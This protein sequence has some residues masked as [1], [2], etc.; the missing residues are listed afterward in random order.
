MESIYKDM[1]AFVGARRAIPSKL[2][3]FSSNFG[4]DRLSYHIDEDHIRNFA[5]IVTSELKTNE[6]YSPIVIYRWR[7]VNTLLVQRWIVGGSLGPHIDCENG[8]ALS[9]LVAFPLLE[10]IAQKWTNAWDDSGKAIVEIPAEAGLLAKN[11]KPKCIKLGARVSSFYDKMQILAF[12]LY[13]EFKAILEKFDHYLRRPDIEGLKPAPNLFLRLG[14]RRNAWAHGQSFNAGEPYI[15][16]LLIG[17]L[18]AASI[19]MDREN[20]AC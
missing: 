13:D 6:V 16:S 20:R 7:L 15:I 8:E 5:K 3:I 11:G 2:K 18:Y 14:N 19:N 1:L 10:F 12:N 17:F 9:T 4:G